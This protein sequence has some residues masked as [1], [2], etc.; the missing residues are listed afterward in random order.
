LAGWCAA[1]LIFWGF[2][3]VDPHIHGSGAALPDPAARGP[4]T[5][6]RDEFRAA[7]PSYQ[8]DASLTVGASPEAG[9]AA[10]AGY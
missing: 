1:I 3:A 6:G 5:A 8:V 7:A 2:L 4:A 10:G 9:M